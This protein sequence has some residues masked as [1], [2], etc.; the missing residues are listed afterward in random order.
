MGIARLQKSLGQI[1]VSMPVRQHRAAKARH[2][3]SRG[4]DLLEH[5]ALRRIAVEYGDDSSRFGRIASGEEEMTL[6]IRYD[7]GID[8]HRK[9]IGDDFPA[10]RSNVV[11]IEMMVVSLRLPTRL[12]PWIATVHVYVSSSSDF[13]ISDSITGSGHGQRRQE[14]PRSQGFN[15][16]RRG[17][18]FTFRS[19][20]SARRDG[21]GQR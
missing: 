4:R 10:R 11:A 3:W 17:S 18:R 9:T 6:L 19:S 5:I 21:C 8:Q 20:N 12:P 15:Q 2:D 16:R 7:G 14:M 13:D 1:E